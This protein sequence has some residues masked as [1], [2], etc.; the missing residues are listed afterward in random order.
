[1]AT[2]RSKLSP[3]KLNPPSPTKPDKAVLKPRNNVIETALTGKFDA[4]SM[5]SPSQS[6]I[7][8]V[9]KENREDGKLQI[10]LHPP[11]EDGLTEQAKNSLRSINALRGLTLE[12]VELL[13]QPSV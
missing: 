4:M 8:R 11:Y 12:E 1:M 2:P 6:P 7:K 13:S 3:V 10:N 9:Y 5:N